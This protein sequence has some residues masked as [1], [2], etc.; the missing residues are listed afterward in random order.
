MYHRGSALAIS[1]IAVC[2]VQRSDPT[3]VNSIQSRR[4]RTKKDAARFVFARL[5]GG[6]KACGGIDL[7]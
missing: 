6:V 4:C 2:D 1:K 5:E 7:A 3:L